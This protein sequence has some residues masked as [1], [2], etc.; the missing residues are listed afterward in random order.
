V[1]AATS[2]EKSRGQLL[3]KSTDKTPG[4]KPGVF[5]CAPH[6]QNCLNIIHNRPDRPKTRPRQSEIFPANH[7]KQN[8]LAA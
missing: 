1:A 8:A 6:R 7:E 3:Y 2:I 5:S 4:V